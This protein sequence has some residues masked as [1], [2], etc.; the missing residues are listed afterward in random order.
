MAKKNKPNAETALDQFLQDK[1]L[2]YSSSIFQGFLYAELYKNKGQIHNSSAFNV[3][4][5]ILPVWQY[6]FD[7]ESE[8]IQLIFLCSDMLKDIAAHYDYEY[9]KT[10]SRHR[11]SLLKIVE[12]VYDFIM[13]AASKD[14]DISANN[15]ADE[16]MQKLME[17]TVMISLLIVDISTGA[18]NALE[19]FKKEK[20]FT[21][22][23]LNLIETLT[24]S[25]I[26]LLREPPKNVYIFRIALNGIKPPIWRKFQAPGDLTLEEFHDCIQNIMGWFECHLHSFIIRGEEYQCLDGMEKRDFYMFGHPILDESEYTLD[27]LEL[28]E[29]QKI[30]YIYDFGDGW[31]HTIT[32]SKI[33]SIE[34][35]TTT[36]DAI[37]V[38]CLDG[39]RACPPEDCGGIWGYE[40]LLLTLAKPESERDEEEQ[41]RLD[42][43]DVSDPE[44]FDI[45]EINELLDI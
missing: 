25:I 8:F 23:V 9:D 12:S 41:E 33:I 21:T 5:R 43:Y 7:D 36:E 30:K 1:G 24:D 13:Y 35:K 32:V 31:E 45:D 40:E 17:T 15:Q 20:E 16:L 18:N 34:D 14:L 3:M 2:P 22:N 28:T 37:T 4:K 27:S 10:V 11:D 19:N 44:E 38:R 42:Y 26:E 39:K 6:F 29:K